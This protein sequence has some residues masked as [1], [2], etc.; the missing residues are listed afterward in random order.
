VSSRAGESAS[1]GTGGVRAHETRWLVG[2]LSDEELTA[3]LRSIELERR[4][5]EAELAQVIA[6]SERR[7]LHRCER[8]RSLGAWLRSHTNC[9]GATSARRRRAAVLASS[10]P[11]AVDALAEGRIGVDQFD[12][13]ARAR[14]NPRCGDRLADHAELLLEWCEQ[15]S[16]EE[17]RVC[18]HRWEA[19]ADE[20][21]AHRDREAS[22][23]GRSAFV[24]ALGQG[25]VVSA[26]GGDPLQAAE[27][28]ATFDRFVDAELAR[29]RAE[30][31]ARHGPGGPADLLPRTDRQ[32]RFDAMLAV[33]R[34]S[35]GA[36]GS[37][38][39]A[40]PVVLNVVA[41]ELSMR[42]VLARHQLAIPPDVDELADALH[43]RRRETADG[44]P[45]LADDLV[46]I[47]LDQHVR[48]VVVDEA[49]TVIDWGRK[50]RLFTGPAREAALLMARRC[51]R[52][53]CTIHGRHCQVDHLL[54]WGDG[55]LTDQ[56]NAGAVCSHDNRAKHDLGITV[57][58]TP[59]GY[60]NWHRADGSY[61]G[62]VGR[63]RRPDDEEIARHIRARLASDRPPRGQ[64]SAMAIGVTTIVDNVSGAP[65]RVKSVN[66]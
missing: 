40:A 5:L 64:V 31:D 44:T 36:E 26:S 49:G 15:L 42:D 12:E 7:E 21:G 18:I 22:V 35:A 28:V 9:S 48:G 27:M 6:E 30:R 19:L 25:V 62:P 53:G 33:F 32:R 34:A 54:G 37:P 23:E 43:R 55:G 51:S 29:D 4:R 2:A 59:E 11:A 10:I 52:P 60:L 47:A 56:A 46:T 8:H 50:R 61:I 65:S 58:R 17:S 41:D 38:V 16:F 57:R 3:R 13:L 63:R 39:G 1:V 20:D 14:S 66:R 24:G 45:L